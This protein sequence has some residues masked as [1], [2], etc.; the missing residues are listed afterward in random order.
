MI[1]IQCCL[2][3]SVFFMLLYKVEVHGQTAAHSRATLLLRIL[4]MKSE[5][6]FQGRSQ[7]REK[8]LFSFDMS[9]RLHGTTWLRLDRFS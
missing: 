3:C 1:E 8:R 4:C 6:R 7:H 2:M 5:E 9:V